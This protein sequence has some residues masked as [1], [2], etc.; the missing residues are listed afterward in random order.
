MQ[1]FGLTVNCIFSTVM[2]IA[3]CWGRWLWAAWGG[4]LPG[5][6]AL[7]LLCSWKNVLEREVTICSKSKQKMFVLRISEVFWGGLFL[8]SFGRRLAVADKWHS[9]ESSPCFKP[10]QTTDQGMLSKI[11][12]PCPESD[13]SAVHSACLSGCLSGCPQCLSQCLS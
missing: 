1:V 11:S 6:G 8:C 10:F 13:A 9:Q 5:T 7:G 2:V 12:F 4:L 3:G